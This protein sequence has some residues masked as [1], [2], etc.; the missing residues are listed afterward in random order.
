MKAKILRYIYTHDIIIRNKFK[1]YNNFM[2]YQS[3]G[4]NFE[5]YHNDD[6]YIFKKLGYDNLYIL[7]SYNKLK[8]NCIAITVNE[9]MN[10]ANINNC[11]ISYN[12]TDIDLL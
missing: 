9:E 4:S 7:Y 5:V 11:I 10:V 12:K 8:D 2:N 1:N 6:I 3:D